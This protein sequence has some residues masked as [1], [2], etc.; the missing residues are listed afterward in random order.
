MNLKYAIKFSKSIEKQI[1][2]EVFAE[3]SNIKDSF[4][5]ISK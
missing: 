3:V 2:L 1:F 4:F 5:V